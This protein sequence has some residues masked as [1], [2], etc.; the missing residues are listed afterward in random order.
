MK[1]L[2]TILTLLITHNLYLTAQLSEPTAKS[3]FA[4]LAPPYWQQ[5]VDYTIDVSLNDVEHTLDGFVKMIYA[6]N[7]PDTLSWIWIHCWPNAYKN[8]KTAFSEQMLANGRTDFYFSDKSRKGYINRLDFRVDGEAARMEDHPRYIDIIKIILPHPLPP[9]GTALITTPFHEQLPFNFSR[10]GHVGNTY[11]V[12]QWYPKPAV[13]DSKGWHPIPYLD[14]GEFYSEFGDYDV[15]ITVPRSYVVAST[16]Q[17]QPDSSQDINTIQPLSTGGSV[18]TL[19]YLQK[20]VHDFAWFADKKYK[21]DHD[22]LHL[23]SGRIIDIYACYKPAPKSLWPKAI[24]YIKDAIRFHSSLIGEYPYNTVSVAQIK[25]AIPEGMEYPTIA[26]I[27]DQPTAP[28]LDLTI[29]HEI[30]H[31]WFYSALGTDERRFP[32]MDEGINTYYDNRYAK[33]KYP[34]WHPYMSNKPGQTPAWL[35]KKMPEDQD[36]L[37]LNTLAGEKKDQPIS[38]SSEDFTTANYQL[39]AYSKAA[40]WMRQLEDSLGRPLFDSCM[41]VWFFKWQFKHP[42]PEDFQ[43]SITTSSHK[44]LSTLFAQL[45]QKG[46]L[47][48]IQQHRKLQP[49]LLFNYRNTDKIDYINLLP[50]ICYNKYDGF[51]AGMVIHN[52]NLP[53]DRFQFL[54]APL[55]AAGSRQV[56]GIA[57]ISYSWYP[58]KRFKKITLALWSERF[59]SLSSVD[60]NGQKLFGGYYKLTPIL[61]VQL[62]SSYPRSTRQQYIEWKTF[63]IGEK[64][65]DGYVIKSTDSLP[66]VRN[67]G[68][69]D[70]RYLNQ[71]SLHAED[72]RVLYPWKALL[73]LQQGDRFYRINFT[74]NYFFN[75][76]AGGG[77][78]LRLF[79]AKFG[80]LGGRDAGLYTSR[81]QPKLTGVGGN[82]DYTYGNYFLGRNEYTGFSS[83]QIMSRD[84]DLKIRV[85]SFPWLEGRSDNWVSSLNFTTTLPASLIPSWLPLKIFLDAGTYSNAWKQ[86]ALTSRFLY[87]GGLQLS[88]FHNTIN[89]YAPIF[90]SSDFRDQL[91]TLPDQNTFWKRL[92]FSID[93]QNL[94]LRK[95]FGNLPL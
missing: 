32:W 81:F 77:M 8:D 14:Q 15:R 55:Y 30:G 7:S 61:R 65:P 76:A 64:G 56:N 66:Y 82:E 70:F 63:L 47:P 84:G 59:S 20:N 57:G 45:D 83:Q 75:Y 58:D 78:Q 36:R 48:P 60:S 16:G 43:T 33:A 37:L 27:S 17:L 74:G 22:T 41:Q 88:L 2:I 26:A 23:P 72:K 6:N 52:Y 73:Q 11:Q 9:G 69:Y 10:G 68:K 29:Q 25:T 21:T 19:R 49:T 3:C 90:Y 53:F 35:L 1:R 39:V 85:P 71:L 24:Q 89:F 38:T 5:K 4:L 95:I 28:G 87:V 18:K 92:S 12:T 31:N 13:Y 62:G 34:G 91:R 79:A 93:L 86:D 80:Y 42:Y 67:M 51:M 40:A 46:S 54:A 44:D 50:A 94:D